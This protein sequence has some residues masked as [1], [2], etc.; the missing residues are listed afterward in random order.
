M[1]G[2]Y[3]VGTMPEA[4]GQGIGTAVTLAIC[5]EA[6]KLGYRLAMLEATEMAVGLYER[7]GFQQYGRTSLYAWMP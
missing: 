4:R 6:R 5:A 7:M 1:T 3:A 2:V